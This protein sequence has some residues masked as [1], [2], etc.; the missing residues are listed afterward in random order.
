MNRPKYIYFLFF[1]ILI[2]SLNGLEAQELITVRKIKTGIYL[3]PPFVMKDTAGYYTGMAIDLWKLAAEDLN[4]R[5]EYI[6]YNTWSE[7]MH[8]IISGDVEIGVSSISVTYERAKIL[9]YT[10]PWY[11]SGLRIMVKTSGNSSIWTELRRNGHLQAYLWI[12]LALI[13]LT[14]V[15]TIIHRRR[16]PDF[17]RDWTEGFSESLYR[18]VLAIKTGVVNNQNYSWIGK[19]LAVFWMLTGIGLVAY[20]TSSI[21]SSMTTIALT[22]DIHSLNDLPGKRVGVLEGTIGEEYMQA[23]GV[24]TI[25]YNNIEQ[26]AEALSN[27]DIDAIVEDAPV[28]EY[29]SFN[30]ADK[31]FRI[32]GNIFHPDKLAFA[33]NKRYAAQMDSLS[34]VIIKLFEQGKINEIRNTYFGNIH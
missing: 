11:D 33:S 4:L 3:N 28:L 15:L 32:V 30:N 14:V 31:Q 7:L 25:P 19:V 1:C 24:P 18:L 2:S 12:T 5:P 21:T 10:F 22:H 6:E 34:I 16:E 26:A 8:A 29:W 27:N 20:V 9:E 13:V 17:P 23:R